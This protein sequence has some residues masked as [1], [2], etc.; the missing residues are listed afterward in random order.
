V[1]ADS[2]SPP[3]DLGTF[4]GT[5]SAAYGINAGGRAV[6]YAARSDEVP[7]AFATGQD[8]LTLQDLGAL[9]SGLSAQARAINDEGRIVGFSTIDPSGEHV[10]A[11]ITDANGENMRDLGT[12]PNGASSVAYAIN[13]SG[14]VVGEADI[15]TGHRHGFVTGPGGVGMRDVDRVHRGVDS[16]WSR[17]IR[18]AR[19]WAGSGR[20]AASSRSSPT[21]RPRRSTAC[22][23]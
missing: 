12:L 7:R 22:R 5:T 21:R 18:R 15:G 1:A 11:F 9:A 13:A 4:G 17:S 10:H 23:T 8:G 16:S 19:R 20:W 6:G 14:Q 3:I 2:T